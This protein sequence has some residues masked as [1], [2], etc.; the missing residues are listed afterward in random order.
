MFPDCLH[1]WFL[2]EM[3]QFLFWT[4]D[5]KNCSFSRKWFYGVSHLFA[6]R[7][8]HLV[9]HQNCPVFHLETSWTENTISCSCFI[10]GTNPVSSSDSSGNQVEFVCSLPFYEIRS[11]FLHPWD[12]E[13]SIEVSWL[14]LLGP[15]RSLWFQVNCINSC[16]GYSLEWNQLYIL[17]MNRRKS[18]YWS[19]NFQLK[20]TNFGFFASS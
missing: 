5:H 11:S 18:S 16:I 17:L 9:F 4:L 7:R 20:V 1:H 15:G 10:L 12:V 8:I 14:Y 19:D 13:W 2:M 3:I 6:S